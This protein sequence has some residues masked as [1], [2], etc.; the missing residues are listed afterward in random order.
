M[1]NIREKQQLHI[2]YDSYYQ[3]LI[4]K[5]KLLPLARLLH[6]ALLLD[7]EHSVHTTSPVAYN[8]S[9]KTKEANR[10]FKSLQQKLKKLR[11]VG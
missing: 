11:F 6:L 1:Y 10:D 5:I 7:T 4:I 9:K 2:S 8:L 3:L